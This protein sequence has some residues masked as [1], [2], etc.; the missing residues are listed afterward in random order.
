MLSSAVQPKKAPEPISSKEE[1]LAATSENEAGALLVVKNY[2]G[3]LEII[4]DSSPFSIATVTK[5]VTTTDRGK[6]ATLRSKEIDVTSGRLLLSVT[7]AEIYYIN[8][9]N[10]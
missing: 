10:K 9:F 3:K 6:G 4:F 5:N 2:E 1:I 7:P 8:L